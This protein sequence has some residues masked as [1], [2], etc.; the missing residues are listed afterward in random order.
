MIS[1]GTSHLMVI[2]GLHIGLLA[3]IAFV[4]FRGVWSLSPK[5]CRKLPAQYVGVIFSIFAAFGY[6]LLA[7][8]SV[9]TKRAVIMLLAVTM[10]WFF[11]KR[12]SVARSLLIAFVVI[13]LLDFESTYS[14]SFWLSFSAVATLVFISIL[15]QHYKSKLAVTLLPQIYLTIFLIP[16]SVYY[17]GS[18]S[19]VSI[20]ANIVA[21]PLVSFIVMP[22]LLFCLV[23]SYFGL[24]IWFLPIFFL[25]LLYSYLEFLSSH[26]S[27][28]QLIEYWSYFSLTSLLIVLIGVVLIIFPFARS[29]K[30]LGLA[31]CLVFF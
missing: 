18:F 21:I 5:L 3:F 9:P 12:V 11:K 25:R 27:H 7:G 6:S 19:V 14:I 2:S 8:F 10:F 22:L 4:F 30:L 26:S 17:F 29:I 28:I 16:I 23:V 13:L 20:L 31:M 24:K 1:S 15:L